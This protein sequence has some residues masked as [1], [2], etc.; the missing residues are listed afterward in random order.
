MRQT[1]MAKNRSASKSQA[2]CGFSATVR[3]VSIYRIYVSYSLIERDGLQNNFT[4][5]YRK[6]A[7]EAM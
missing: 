2:S 4:I 7:T 1:V 3:L 5:K 6:K